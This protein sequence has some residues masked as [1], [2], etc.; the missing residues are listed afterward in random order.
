M[1]ATAGLV[2]TNLAVLTFKTKQT[3]DKGSKLGKAQSTLQL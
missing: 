2:Q 3:L 1:P